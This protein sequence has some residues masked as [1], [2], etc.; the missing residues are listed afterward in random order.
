[1]NDILAQRLCAIFVHVSRLGDRLAANMAAAVKLICR[2]VVFIMRRYRK[3]GIYC[4]P[5]S[6]CPSVRHVRVLYPDG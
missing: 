5:V 2:W 4:R 3:R 6:V 1:M